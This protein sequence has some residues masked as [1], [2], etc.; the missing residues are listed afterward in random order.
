MCLVIMRHIQLKFNSIK[1]YYFSLLKNS[2]IYFHITLCCV[3]LTLCGCN[4]NEKLKQ[5]LNSFQNKEIQMP[6]KQMVQYH[7]EEDLLDK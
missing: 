5:Y 4:K 3:L 1:N 6:L 2:M 7:Q